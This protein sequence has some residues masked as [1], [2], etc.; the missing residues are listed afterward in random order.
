MA[1]V[2]QIEAAIGEYHF[3]ALRTPTGQR[4]GQLLPSHDF[5]FRPHR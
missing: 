3:A 4:A 1:E 2:Q 5:V